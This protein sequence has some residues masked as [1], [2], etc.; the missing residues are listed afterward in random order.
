MRVKTWRLIMNCK[1]K[2]LAIVSF[3]FL[4]SCTKKI[5]A[6]KPNIISIMADDMGYSDIG[7]YGGEIS[8]PN[9]DSNKFKR[10]PDLRADRSAGGIGRGTRRTAV[11]G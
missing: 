9:L 4:A 7:C 10:G 8:T 6:E 1:I 3:V 2:V 11:G 5:E